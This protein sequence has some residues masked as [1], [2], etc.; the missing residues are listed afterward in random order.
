[1][2]SA[3]AGLGAALGMFVW[4]GMGT[5]LAEVSIT[6]V[7][8]GDIYTKAQGE[9]LYKPWM[10]ETGNRIVSHIYSGGLDDLKK[11]IK[12]GKITWNLVDVERSAAEKGCAEGLFEKI[13]PAVLPSAPDGTA[14]AED[15]L[16]GAITECAVANVVWSTVVAY[17]KSKSDTGGAPASIADLFDL[18]KFPGRRGLRET[19]RETLELALY[20]DGVAPAD[21]YKILATGYGQDRAFAKLDTIKREI[22]WW[23]SGTQALKHLSDGRVAMTTA[24]NGSLFAAMVADERPYA[25]IWDGQ[26]YNMDF[27]AIP[28]GA[29]EQTATMDF[30]SFASSSQRLAALASWAPFGPARKSA[31]GMVTNYATLPDVPMAAHMPTLPENFKTAI[32]FDYKFWDEHGKNLDKQFKDWLK[33]RRKRIY[34]SII[35]P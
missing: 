13:D 27:W 21:I 6:V 7:S 15:F 2:R 11:Q 24:Y 18:E 12:D 34:S 16:P 14:A 10:A 8:W 17:D 22:V 33:G 4:A 29:P 1:M 28:K 25:V 31:Q 32:P 23:K 20:A 19:A 5:A 35:L 30:L 26:I 9:A 3:R